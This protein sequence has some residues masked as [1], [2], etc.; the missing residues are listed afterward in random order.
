MP[1]VSV[2]VPIFGVEKYIE[3][4]ARS[5]FEQTLG[6]IEYIFVDDCTKDNSITVLERV[7]KDYPNRK[8]Q[9]TILH[10]ETNKGLPQARK[11]GLLSA[12][13][14]YIAHC[15]S[16]DWVD[17][18]LFALMYEKAVEE[19][20]DLIVC[21]Y[22]IHDGNNTIR[23]VQACHSTDIKV[24]IENMLFQRDHW[25][26]WN[27]LIKRSA[28]Y[29][30]LIYPDGNMGEDMVLTLQLVLNCQK[31]VYLQRV[32]YYYFQN[33][34]SITHIQSKDYVVGKYKHLSD[35]S[36]IIFDVYKNSHCY[37]IY[38]NGIDWLW[39]RASNILMPYI[40]DNDVYQLWR[41]HFSGRHISFLLNPDISI[42]RK[43]R[44]ILILIK[45]YYPVNSK[46]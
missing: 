29:K 15:D 4:C 26:L 3:R 42:L 46:V 45:L 7:I 6:D 19:K 14:D 23:K 5:L 28:Y 33:P 31:M 11:T 18:K 20:A 25:S 37:E 43:V 9:I 16:D 17:H 12:R 13:G 32:Y 44:H 22:Q 30:D 21:D 35:N 40:N 38:K 24:Y 10:H 34:N 1:K 2:I 27:K 36:R 39:Y 8:S 41:T